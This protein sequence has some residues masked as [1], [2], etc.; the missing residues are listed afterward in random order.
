[1]MLRDPKNRSDKGEL[2]EMDIVSMGRRPEYPTMYT[3]QK[4]NIR[5]KKKKIDIRKKASMLQWQFLTQCNNHSIA[6]FC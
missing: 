3:E 5:G 2:S 6:I 1:M 4:I